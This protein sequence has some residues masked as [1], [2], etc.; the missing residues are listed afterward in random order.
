MHTTLT[1]VPK[2][3]VLADITEEDVVLIDAFGPDVHSSSAE[4]YRVV[5]GLPVAAAAGLHKALGE[6]LERKDADTKQ[7][8]GNLSATADTLDAALNG[9]RDVAQGDVREVMDRHL[10]LPTPDEDTFI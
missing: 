7:P 6:L 8:I 3:I 4:H 5:L 10:G 1:L 2:S 9:L